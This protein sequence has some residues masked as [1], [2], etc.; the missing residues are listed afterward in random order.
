MGADRTDAF[1]LA[2]ALTALGIVTLAMG[3]GLHITN[4]STVST[5]Y[6]MVVLLVAATSR[7]RVAVT[8]SIAAMLALNF[9]FL[10]PI[11]TFTIADTQNWVALVAFLAVSLVASRLSSIA[12]DRTNEA[13]EQRNE[14]ARLFDLGRDVLQITDTGDAFSV[15]ARAVVRRFDLEFAA[16]AL[17]RDGQWELHPAGPLGL[18]LDQREL[19]AAF[20][21]AQASLEFDAYSRTYAGH[22][23]SVVDGREVRLVPLRVGTRPI[24]VLAAAGRP[25]DA[26]TLD[27]LSGV[28]AIAVERVR[29]LAEVQAGQAAR[30]EEELKTALLASLSH[31]LRTPLTTIQLAASNLKALEL[32]A[33]ERVEQCNLIL[34]ESARL[35]RLFEN[36]LDMARIDADAVANE[37]RWTH[38]SEIVAAAR[39]QVEPILVGHRLEVG[40]LHDEIVRLDPRLTASA[41]AHLLENAAQYA[42]AGSVIHVS[43]G[44]DDCGLVM[45]VRD[46]GPG[47]AA[48][49]MPHLFERFYRGIE[50]RARTS[51]TGM[52]LWIVRGLLAAQG[53]RV[54][55]EN[56]ADG[57]AQFT[58]AIPAVVHQPAATGSSPR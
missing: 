4:A 37:S 15:L 39:D 54:W 20:A 46:H 26:G 12:R 9:F 55:A 11:G 32:T 22:R 24:G 18:R 45:T 56:C 16:V 21:A 27:A 13:L 2:A 23:V 49:D 47:I 3:P 35:T 58:I 19:A 34:T 57:G 51:G 48:V 53:G 43:A 50:G 17:P 1:R 10:P 29:F 30:Q 52:G 38:V 31:D 41:L 7:L 8:T 25:V 44:I 36:V 5:T 6:L 40:I 33:H 14:V 28:V 42:P